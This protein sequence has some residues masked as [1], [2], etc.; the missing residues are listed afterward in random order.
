MWIFIFI[1]FK[2]YLVHSGFMKLIFL[3]SYSFT[4]LYFKHKLYYAMFISNLVQQ[5]VFFY[6]QTV[7]EDNTLLIWFSFLGCVVYQ[8]EYLAKLS[9]YRKYSHIT[10]L[11][12]MVACFAVF[13]EYCHNYFLLVFNMKSNI[14]N[15][16]VIFFSDYSHFYL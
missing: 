6:Y 15:Y 13:S 2:T 4:V 16:I 9:S 5:Q 11:Y 14:N 8:Y 7:G 12:F 10:V 1:L 3:N